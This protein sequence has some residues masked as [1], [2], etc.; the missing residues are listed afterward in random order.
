MGPPYCE[1]WIREVQDGLNFVNDLLDENKE[2]P[3][4]SWLA[5]VEARLTQVV[6]GSD[7]LSRAQAHL[8][9]APLAK[10]LRPR[11]VRLF[12][13]MVGASPAQLASDSLVDDAVGVELIHTAS[14]LHDDVV[15]HARARRGRPSA[16]AVFS[17]GIAVLAG[18]E[19]LAKALRLFSPAVVPVAIDAVAAMARAALLEVELRGRADASEPQIFTIIDGKTA[20]LFSL[21]GAAG[22]ARKDPETASR[23]ALAGRALGRAFQI[24]DDVDDVLRADAERGNDVRERTPTLPLALLAQTDPDIGAALARAWQREVTAGPALDELVLRIAH[25]GAPMRALAIGARE[26]QELVALLAPFAHTPAHAT[27][28]QVAHELAV[29]VNVDRALRGAA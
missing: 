6:S 9:T 2:A 17:D 3:M 12:A 15:D 20:A 28:V 8:V 18:D 29:T 22:G 7:A 27:L 5:R 25:S 24:K 19:L 4:D 23:M 11:A 10:R 16:N 13:E 21:C 14:L 1:A 26:V